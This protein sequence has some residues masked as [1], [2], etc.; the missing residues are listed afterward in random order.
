MGVSIWFNQNLIE[1]RFMK[2]K[3]HGFGSCFAAMYLKAVYFKNIKF[4]N[5]SGY[6]KNI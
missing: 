3:A 2:F 5:C 1:L 6:L 4:V